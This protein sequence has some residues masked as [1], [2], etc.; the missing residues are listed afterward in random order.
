MRPQLI[1]C[2]VACAPLAAAQHQDADW[3]LSDAL[4]VGDT[5]AEAAHRYQIEGTSSPPGAPRPGRTVTGR[6]A[7]DVALARSRW[8]PLE[9]PLV[10]VRRFGGRDRLKVTLDGVAL[11]DWASDR[12]GD[13][14]YVI[15]ASRLAGAE[16]KRL[17]RVRLAVSSDTPFRSERVR[18]YVARDVE[19]LAGRA[20]G[21]LATLAPA[22]TDPAQRALQALA[23]LVE[24]GIA[25]GGTPG[26]QR[27][28]AAAQGSPLPAVR[29]AG[30]RHARRI[31]IVEALRAP[32]TDAG[33][34]QRLGLRAVADGFFEEARGAFLL[35][36]ALAPGDPDVLYRLAEAEEYC[37][38]PAARVADLCARAGAAARVPDPTRWRVLVAIRDRVL[39][40]QGAE[41]A[42]KPEEVEKIH[43][44]WGIV[45]RMVFGASRGWLRLDTTFT[46]FSDPSVHA[47]VSD[48]GL[49][50]PPDTICT[51]GSY[52]G[53]MS[54]R[55][56]GPS[57]TAGPD[58][59]PSG[60]A[61]TDIG[62]W[63]DWEVFFH[64]W[65][66]QFD[67]TAIF[68]EMGP[69]YPVTHDSDGCG[70]QPIPTMGSGHRAS[71]RYYV[72]PG[73]Y[74]RLQVAVPPGAGAIERWKVAGP[75]PGP[76]GGRDL[77]APVAAAGEAALRPP[78]PAAGRA[79][80]DVAAGAG[81]VVDLGKAFPDAPEHA[82]F[83]AHAW[84]RV[85]ERR[86]A[87]L[88]L[89]MND[90]A[91]L[92]VNGRV[93]YRGAYYAV[94]RWADR[95]R[96]D[97]VGPVAT[98][99][100]GWNSVLVKVERTGGG[101]GFSV[102]PLDLEGTPLNGIETATEVGDFR[103][104]PAREPERGRRYRWVEVGDDFTAR[105]PRLEAADLDRLT[106]LKG[107]KLSGRMLV[108][109]PGHRNPA[110]RW[111]DAPEREDRRLDNFLNW[112]REGLAVLRYPS[113]RGTRDLVFVRPEWQELALR[114]L[115]TADG[116][117]AADSLI[118]Y[119]R[120]EGRNVL[121]LD[122][123]LPADL[124]EDEQSLL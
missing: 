14:A 64:E 115:R 1:A 44:E 93:A 60:A 111:R 66:H 98:L 96:P 21:A 5:A 97:M 80:R 58:C 107:V 59:G 16:G 47:L 118:G 9:G 30:R 121:V 20:S 2:L 31:A 65:N 49:I 45:T 46:T 12:D 8:G 32:G 72:T 53:V 52:D 62:T 38:A 69:G 19:P 70:P 76:A 114:L 43:R 15:E 85:P 104:P 112:E 91:R 56:G 39:D 23:Q 79:W 3:V 29:R 68:S 33:A 117:P 6:E 11:P 94:A 73:M 54:F 82:F 26:L 105:L 101:A 120:E 51:E 123:T 25:G 78:A 103:L 10:I 55:P 87:R 75:F 113:G 92:F 124:P 63:C 7:F 40:D 48:D 119:V 35:A 89:G 27:L 77:D 95:N 83:L 67:W 74:R 106:G 122:V 17:E 37:R 116:I 24:A 99:E 86:D 13:H 84:V 57:V 71:M 102:R 18:C 36:D 81:G 88:W 110:A 50:R 22:G 4:D 34:L 108:T 61:I 41:R 90:G 109:A 100:A 28:V 42:L